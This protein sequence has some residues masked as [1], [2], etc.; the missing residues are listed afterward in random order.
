MAANLLKSF[1]RQGPYS[2]GGRA[3]LTLDGVKP[4][5]DFRRDLET[6]RARADRNGHCFALV[7][8]EVSGA[9]RESAAAAA[10]AKALRQ[11][12]RAADEFGWYD[13]TRIGVLLYDATFEGAKVFAS[14]VWESVAETGAVP[15]AFSIDVYPSVNTSSS[16]GAPGGNGS[17]KVN[18]RIP[19]SD[20]VQL[21]KRQRVVREGRSLVEENTFCLPYRP[22]S[23]I[24]P[25][26]SGAGPS[27][28][29]AFT[30]KVP[31]PKR[32][33]D[34][35][36]AITGLALLSPLFLVVTIL[37]KIVSPGSAFFKQQRVGHGGKIFMLIKFRTMKTGLDSVAHKEYLTKL[38][39]SSGNGDE[40][41][42]M[43]KI[44]DKSQLIPIGGWLRKTCIDELPQLFNVLRGEM[45]L[46]GPRPPIPYE[47]DEYQRW[48]SLRFDTVPGMTGL[49]QVSGK[50]RLTFSQMVRLDI[51]YA[52]H[53][54]V[55]LDMKILLR[56]PRAILSQMRDKNVGDAATKRE[57]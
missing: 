8:F 29:S 57:A 10:L 54:S 40:G 20:D 38:I 53:Q 24:L 45:S 46:V 43:T 27:L 51:Q 6:E 4:C 26:P 1:L 28:R 30:R 18:P 35:V 12:M 15:A 44:E 37:I 2:W 11:R 33:M 36:A 19:N 5:R 13:S 49:W 25:Y 9:E 34:V 31:R 52:R 39:K 16:Q 48:Y 3:S 56:T 47:V 42:P 7:C 55:W 23:P 21:P 17:V 14:S 50:N 41:K 22:I 32:V